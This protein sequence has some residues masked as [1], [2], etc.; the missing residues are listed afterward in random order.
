MM[1]RWSFL[2]VFAAVAPMP[3]PAQVLPIVRKTPCSVIASIPHTITS[4]GNYC[5]DADHLTESGGGIEIASNDV[6]LDCKGHA[7]TKATRGP[8]YSAGIYTE[9]ARENVTIQNCR[10]KDFGRGV[11][12]GGRNIR[13]LDNWIDGAMQ[14]GIAAGGHS[15][16]VIGNRITNTYDDPGS[17][18]VSIAVYPYDDNIVTRG[19]VI[20]DNVVV[21]ATDS[22]SYTGIA[23]HGSTAPVIMRNQVLDL[24]PAEGSHAFAIVLVEGTMPTTAATVKGNVLMSRSPNVKALSGVAASCSNNVAIGL[25]EN[26]FATCQAGTGNVSIP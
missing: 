21:G 15:A 5:L 17:R 22:F 7:I 14:E 6:N 13:I 11:A 18:Q 2:L 4:P 19:Q 10:I 16:Q 23:V 12:F 26:A 20:R 24:R 9:S 3:T 8:F 1:I 25:S